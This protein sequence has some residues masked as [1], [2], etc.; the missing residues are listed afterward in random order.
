MFELLTGAIEIALRGA[1]S[2]EYT[3]ETS[4]IR[5]GRNSK[6]RTYLTPDAFPLQRGQTT[7]RDWKPVDRIDQREV[8]RARTSASKIVKRR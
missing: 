5:C 6:L 1:V 4:Q 2:T 3:R 7:E 8:P